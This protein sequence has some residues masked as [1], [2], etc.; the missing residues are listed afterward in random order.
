MLCTY[1]GCCN[2]ATHEYRGATSIK[3]CTKCV[4]DRLSSGQTV[5]IPLYSSPYSSP[6]PKPKAIAA[7]SWFEAI[8]G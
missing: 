1:P 5:M 2:S 8:P 3:W 7:L 4:N 6:K